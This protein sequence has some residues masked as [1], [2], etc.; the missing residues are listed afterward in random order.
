[1]LDGR[2][3]YSK[4]KANWLGKKNLESKVRGVF[5]L[6]DA[7]GIGVVRMPFGRVGRGAGAQLPVCVTRPETTG[8]SATGCKSESGK[9]VRC[10]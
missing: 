3:S 5:Q 7:P 1:V 6:D 9:V 10:M 4:R 8:R 2:G